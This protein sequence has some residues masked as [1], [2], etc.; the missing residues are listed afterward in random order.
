MAIRSTASKPRI[1]QVSQPFPG[2]FSRSAP[3]I[4]FLIS[5]LYPAGHGRRAASAVFV[6]PSNVAAR[7]L[8]QPASCGR[9]KFARSAIDL[10]VLTI[11]DIHQLVCVFEPKGRQGTDRRGTSASPP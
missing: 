2:Y 7:R 11:E 6:K 9:D 8:R 10:A 5:A 3:A 1:G 4:V